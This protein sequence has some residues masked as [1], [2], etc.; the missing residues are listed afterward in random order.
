MKDQRQLR[1]KAP[2]QPYKDM[3][4]K[5]YAPAILSMKKIAS[6]YRTESW[7]DSIC[8]MGKVVQTEFIILF[9]IQLWQISL[10]QTQCFN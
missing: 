4:D 2:C 9:G 8:S 6:T 3:S 5:F 7:E 10:P 1:S